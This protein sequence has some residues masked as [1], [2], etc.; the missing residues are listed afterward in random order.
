MLALL[1]R[2]SARHCHQNSYQSTA[3]NAHGSVALFALLTSRLKNRC[4]DCVG[5]WW[6]ESVLAR[7]PPLC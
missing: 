3:C 7:I 5:L 2:L 1:G 4:F 6:D